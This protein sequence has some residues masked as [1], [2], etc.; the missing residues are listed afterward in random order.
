MR[1]DIALLQVQNVMAA[2]GSH[3][4]DDERLKLDTLEGETDLFAILP[5]LLD[6]LEDEEG[7]IAVL[8]EQISDRQARK[9]RATARKDAYREAIANLMACAELDKVTLPE[10]T[11]SVRQVPPKPIVTDADALPDALCTFTRKPNMAAIKEA[12]TLPEGVAFDNGGITLTVR[13]K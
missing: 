7:N 1:T 10:A 13:R 9:T 8:A 3:F 2:L 5:K 4:D 11:L 12:E 6:R